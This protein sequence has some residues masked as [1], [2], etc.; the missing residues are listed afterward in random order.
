MM[1]TTLRSVVFLT[2]IA[3]LAA[4]AQAAPGHRIEKTTNREW[5]FNYFPAENADSLG[6]EAPGFDDSMWPAVAVPHTWQ[7]FETTGKVHPFIYDAAEKDDSYWWFGWGWYRK[8]FSIGKE[9]AGRKVFVEFDG[10]QKYSK[11][12]VNGKPVGDHKG[13]YNGFYFDVTDFVKLGEDNV[14]AVAVNNRQSDP[15][16]IPPMSAGNFDIYGGIYRDA[17]IVIKDRLHIPFQ[18]SAKHQGG[19]F[20]TTPRVSE[21]AAEVRVRTWVRNDYAAPKDCELRTTIA[22][23]E[24]KTVQ[25]FSAKKTIQPGELAEFDQTSQRW[26]RPSRRTFP[27]RHARCL[28]FPLCAS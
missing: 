27:R 3:G 24:G 26:C 16:Q 22:G 18:G 11:V 6:C 15:F 1:K 9:R 21:S 4:A 12:F 14:L 20:V 5:T 7:T 28:A 2:V 19:T 13:G 23:A 10:V 17:R 8:H 25:T